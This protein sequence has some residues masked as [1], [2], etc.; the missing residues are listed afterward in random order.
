MKNT[1]SICG[2]Q[3]VENSQYCR[4]HHRAH[5]DLELAFGKW[6]LAYAN[7]ID[8]KTFLERVQQFS[9]TGAKARDVAAFLL[10]K[11]LP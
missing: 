7:E 10:R 5:L 4:L 2:S 6:K 8:K 3:T 9:E 1:C 11:G